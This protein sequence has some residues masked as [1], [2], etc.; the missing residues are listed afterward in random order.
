MDVNVLKN[1][2]EFETP[3]VRKTKERNT[4]PVL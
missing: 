3:M 4:N 2:S 1:V